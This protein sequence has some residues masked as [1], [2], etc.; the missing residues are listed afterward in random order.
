MN[1]LLLPGSEAESLSLAVAIL[2]SGGLVAFP[3]DTVYGLG[4]TAFV[5][6]AV[7]AIFT[8]KNRPE[9]KAVPVLIAD[10]EDLEK[11]ADQ[12]APAARSLAQEFWPGPLTLILH[13]H[14]LLPDIISKDGTVGVRIPDHPLARTLLRLAGPLA[15]SSAN[16]SGQENPVT[17]QQVFQQLS[18]RIDLILDGGQA[19][20]GMPSTVV[21]CLGSSLKVIRQGPIPERKLKEFLDRE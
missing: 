7:E 1:T 12:V 16:I 15:V 13:R 19:P 20:G 8:A 21:E 18:G 14:V 11:V 3:T 9:E 10:V 5:Q 2:R 6:Q 17:A 4:G